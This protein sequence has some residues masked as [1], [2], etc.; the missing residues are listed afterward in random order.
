V[1]SRISSNA[2]SDLQRLHRVKQLKRPEMIAL[3]PEMLSFFKT[4]VQKRQSKLKVIAECWSRLIPESLLDHCALEGFSAGTLKVIVDSSPHL[5]E[6]KQLLLSGLQKQ[7][8][9]ACKSTGLKKIS[10]KSGRWYEGEGAHRRVN[11]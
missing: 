10:L 5:Y 3:G 9:I 2:E 4:N 11:F 7:L 8:L 1:R 6:L